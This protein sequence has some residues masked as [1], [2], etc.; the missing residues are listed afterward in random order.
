MDFDLAN[1]I[2]CGLS[3]AGVSG[4]S[5]SAG[6]PLLY[7]DEIAALLKLCRQ[8]GIYTRVVT[9]SY[10]ART[11]NASDRLVLEL[12]E[13][14]LCQLRLSFSRWHQENV[15]KRN[16][17]NAARSCQKVGMK[18]FISFITD[19]TN[20][21]DPYEQYLR[22]HGLIFF[23]EPVIYAGRAAAFKYRPIHTDYQANC[24]DMNPYLT[25]DLDMYACCDAGMYFP[26]TNFFYLGN[27]KDHT[28]EQLFTKAETDR[29]YNCIRTMGVT[30]IASFIGM[31][32]RKIITYRKCELCHKLFN[33]PETLTMLQDNVSRI[34]AWHR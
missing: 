24:C 5:F 8:L 29:L 20:D 25:P 22:D 13:H 16:V 19:F 14:G 26:K 21:D 30:H 31:K 18:Y 28:I 33:T 34:E 17:L 6:E 15:D 9:N 27:L 32:A 12:K 2:I 23:P 11:A 3:R 4:I 10:W 1:E 7:F